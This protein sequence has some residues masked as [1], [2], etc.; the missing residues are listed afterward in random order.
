MSKRRKGKEALLMALC[1]FLLLGW[2]TPSATGQEAPADEIPLESGFESLDE[3]ETLSEWDTIEESIEDGAEQASDHRGFRFAL[4]ALAFTVLAG[5]LVRSKQLRWTRTVL[6]LGSLALLGFWNGGCP[7]PISSFQNLLLWAMNVDVPI[8]SLV[9]FLALIPITYVFGRVWCGWICHLG[10]FQEFLYKPNRLSFLQG[11][12]AQKTMRV[13]RYA[14]VAALIV[15]LVWT[16]DNQ[17]VHIDPFKVAFNLRSFYLTGWLLLGFLML[18]SLYI[19]RPF[20]RSACPVGLILGW[21]SRLP[22]ASKLG[23]RESCRTCKLCGNACP[24]G[25]IRIHQREVDIQHGDCLSCG[26]CMDACRRDSIYFH[27]KDE[28]DVPK[29]TTPGVSDWNLPLP[30][31][32]PNGRSRVRER[33]GG[34]PEAAEGRLGTHMGSRADGTTRVSR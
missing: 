9:W 13:L 14:L 34:A 25:A 21:V 5:I 11:E 10:A 7:C 17:F 31:G 23:V 28:S 24:S 15:Q 6:L 16:K 3:F 19:Y 33:S 20:C 29:N 32:K 27:R 30:H 8:H 1:L 12:R 26:S 18:S 4:I 2:W 22:Y